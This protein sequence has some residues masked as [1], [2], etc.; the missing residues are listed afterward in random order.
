MK[1]FVRIRH[2]P[3]SLLYWQTSNRF[4]RKRKECC[5]QSSINLSDFNA[6]FKNVLTKL[7]LELVDFV[8]GKRSVHRSVCDSEALGGLSGLGVGELVSEFHALD[9]IASNSTGHFEKVV[10]N[11]V[12]RDPEGNILVDRRVLGVRLE[13][14]NLSSIELLVESLVIG[15]EE[16][17]IRNLKENHGQSLQSQTKGPSTAVLSSS[18]FQNLGV[19]NTASKNLEPLSVVQNFALKGR[20]CEGEEILRPLL[21]DRAKEVIH[22]SL[23]D[24]L[25][26]IGNHFALVRGQPFLLGKAIGTLDLVLVK[27]LDCL[28]LVKGRVVGGINLVTTINVTRAQEA[29]VTIS[30]VHRLVGTGVGSQQG[31]VVNVI[32][33]TGG[34]SG[35]V[36]FDSQIVKALLA[37]DDRILGIKDLVFFVEA[38]EVILD[39]GSDNA[40][41]VVLLG[42]ESSANQSGNVGRNVVVGVVVDITFDARISL[43]FGGSSRKESLVLGVYGR[44]GK[45]MCRCGGSRREAGCE[46][47]EFH[48]GRV[49]NKFVVRNRIPSKESFV[50]DGMSSELFLDDS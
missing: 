45:R 10:L 40:N 2:G 15:P 20:F 9:K 6:E 26:V 28:K 7:V 44:G 16:T 35:V 31:F 12:F 30:Q 32:S 49:V 29:F 24:I 22:E 48:F 13:L 47:A 33:V 5:F 23:Q 1:H 36:R 50:V 14:G 37:G 41:G 43:G 27:K 38:V 46:M 3:Y 19:N 17:N 25:E 8:I 39:L 42:M 34:S 11:K 4:N 18:H 21:F